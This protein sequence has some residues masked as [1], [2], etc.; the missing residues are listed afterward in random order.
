MGA[1]G[2]HGHRVVRVPSFRVNQ[3]PV[4]PE[5]MIAGRPIDPPRVLPFQRR[6]SADLY[7]NLRRI[8]GF[9]NR[10]VGEFDALGLADRP[11]FQHDLAVNPLGPPGDPDRFEDFASCV[12]TLMDSGLSR[13]EA[14]RVCGSWEQNGLDLQ[15]LEGDGER[16]RQAVAQ[17]QPRDVGGRYGPV[18]RFPFETIGGRRSAFL[19]WLEDQFQLGVIEHVN[20][21]SYIRASYKRGVTHADFALRKAG[22]QLPEDTD[23]EDLFAAP[24]HADTL[25]TLMTR[26]LAALRGINAAM[27]ADIGR[28]LA[29]GLAQGWNPHK[30]AREINGRVDAVGI[31]RSRLLARTETQN[32]VAQGTLN[33]FKQQGVDEVTVFAEFSTAGDARVCPECLTLEGRV[34]DMDNAAGIIPVHPDC[35]CVWLPVRN[36][37]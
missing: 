29:E 14:E 32:A 25:E 17:K 35:R 15:F 27:G 12:D 1:R 4:N 31:H 28:T 23:L 5:D 30:T 21:R 6:Y 9:V 7:K 2:H 19:T 3:P 22:V 26:D 18:R 24:V 20:H 37:G 13:E 8:K 16:I 33:R 34:F 36:R 10:T 11:E